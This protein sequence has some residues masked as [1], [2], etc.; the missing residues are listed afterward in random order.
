MKHESTAKSKEGKHTRVH[1]HIHTHTHVCVHTHTPPT[2]LQ[3]AKYQES[4][5]I[6]H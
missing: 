2:A 5:V 4:K 1:V 3:T 6:G